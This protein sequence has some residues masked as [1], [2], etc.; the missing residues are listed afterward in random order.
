MPRSSVEQIK[1]DE[2]KVIKKLLT[3][4]SESIDKIAKSCGFS[5][6][7]V[8]R[9]MKRLEQ[10]NTIWGYTAVI[11]HEKQNQNS[12]IVLIKKTSVPIGAIMEKIIQRDLEKKYADKENI[13]I[14]ESRY[15]NGIY[16]WVI[17]F[18]AKDIREAKK[19]CNFLSQLFEDHISEMHLL[20]DIFTV[21]K[22]GILNPNVNSLEE[23]KLP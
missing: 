20:E 21:K 9:I 11:D 18:T 23:F 15:L 16:D 2:K 7:K 14:G 22:Q 10:N 1:E 4:A 12:Y 19:F 3:D 8:W 6:Q 17:C 5:R 13:H